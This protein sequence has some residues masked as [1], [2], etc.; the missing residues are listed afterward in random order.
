MINSRLVLI[1]S[2]ALIF[3]AY[4]GLPSSLT[5]DGHPINA[6]YGFAAALLSAIKDLD[7]EYLVAAFDLPKPT[8]RHIEY[9]E[10]KAHRA[11]MPDDLVPQI[12]YCKKVLAA[13]NIPVVQAEGYEGEDII[14]TIVAKLQNPNDK[15]QIESIIVTGDS[16]TFQ[17]VDGCTK[18]YSMARGI[19]QAV[20][21]DENKVKD[22]YGV[23]PEQFVDLKALKG[24]ASDNIP[25]VKG[26]GEKTACSLIQTFSSLENLYDNIGEKLTEEGIIS[27][28][29]FLIS[30]QILNLNDQII[31]KISKNMEISPNILRLL[32]EQK[33]NAFLSQKLSKISCDAPIEFKLNSARVH[34]YDEKKVIKLFNE[35]G[36]K[37]LI[38]RVPK[39]TRETCQQKLF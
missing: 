8:K 21:Y 37:S 30:K 20:M 7:P 15:C 28:S 1:D 17:L 22:R 10:Y 39:C 12:Q 36:F 25:G 13:L 33:E 11:P 23:T 26:I 31:K 27:K 6:A 34:D 29:E 2:F 5:K 3:R 18:V 14:A 9:V 24:D 32:I 16:D 4:F 35:L 19:Q 38:P